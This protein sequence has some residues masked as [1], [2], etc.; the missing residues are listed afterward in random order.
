ME[1]KARRSSESLLN[2]KSKNRQKEES[3]ND[4]FMDVDLNPSLLFVS[5][6]SAA[7][8]AEQKISK[9]TKDN[10]NDPKQNKK[11]SKTADLFGTSDEDSSLSQL[12]AETRQRHRLD[13]IDPL[14]R[15]SPRR[16]S[17]HKKKHTSTDSE[18]DSDDALRTSVNKVTKLLSPSKREKLLSDKHLS[19]SSPKKSSK[20]SPLD[21]KKSRKP[22]DSS[23]DDIFSSRKR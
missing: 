20:I 6:R 16:S 10:K 21:G 8:K 19:K 2:F 13:D 15:K 14:L 22:R 1:D 7:R 3:D 5:Q 23:G 12:V 18:S 9:K 4:S 11:G 17:E